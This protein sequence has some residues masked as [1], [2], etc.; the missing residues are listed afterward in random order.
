MFPHTDYRPT[1]FL[2]KAISLR[3][4]HFVRLDFLSPKLGI[5]LRP[6]PMKRAPMPE[7]AIDE[8]SDP[9]G[10]KNHIST[11]A[12]TRKNQPIHP[13]SQAFAVNSRT[14]R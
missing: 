12:K 14:N 4:P 9:G 5:Q 10:H 2:E 6:R 1:C 7:A 11:P 13:K 8:D 3:V